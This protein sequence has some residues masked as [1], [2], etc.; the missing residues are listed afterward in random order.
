MDPSQSYPQQQGA[1]RPTGQEPENPC[2]LIVNYLPS[3]LTQDHLQ[4][5]F[6][7]YGSLVSCKLVT[8]RVTG[9]S[10]GYGFVEY[11]AP[12]EAK[13]AIQTLNKATIE[14][15]T[16]KVSYAR[17]PSPELRDTNLFVSGLPDDLSQPQLEQLFSQYGSV[18]HCHLLTDPA[19]RSRCSG[20]VRMSLNQEAQAAIRGLDQKVLNGKQISVKVDNPTER[21]HNQGGRR[22]RDGGGPYQQ[23][24]NSFSNMQSG[25][26][27]FTIF[28]YNL[29][30]AGED[31]FI[32]SYFSQFGQIQKMSVPRHP[33]GAARGF[34]FVT[35]GSVEE[36]NKA[37]MTMNGVIVNGKELQVSL[38]TDRQVAG[39]DRGGGRGR[40]GHYNRGGPDHGQQ[41]QYHNQQPQYQN[42]PSGYSG[43]T[44]ISAQ[45]S[46]QQ[47]GQMPGQVQD[48]Q[49]TLIRLQTRLQEL[50][51][52]VD[53]SE[54]LK[55]TGPMNQPG[56]LSDEQ[57]QAYSNEYTQLMQQYQQI[58]AQFQTRQ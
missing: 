40:G 43:Y 23:Q 47:G 31:E 45:N 36:A 39:G 27:G 54:Q 12:E 11:S 38:K 52:I 15:K 1:A 17:N 33:T 5:L 29:P 42:Q 8:S 49:Q 9:E 30:A 51:S 6:S 19:G 3:N 35:Y 4:A 46:V 2:R 24:Q 13:L 37:I 26:N 53:R 7:Q 58:Q 20:F 18:I 56:I 57:T 22:S 10:L 48:V 55:R 34:G 21:K 25:A 44:Q 28:I 14:N 50:H 32:T 41:P 16:L